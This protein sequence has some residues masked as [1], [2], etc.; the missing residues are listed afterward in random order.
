M[1]QRCCFWALPLSPAPDAG[2]LGAI[3]H[4]A[5]WFVGFFLQTGHSANGLAHLKD[6]IPELV[7]NWEMSEMSKKGSGIP[8]LC[9]ARTLCATGHSLGGAMATLAAYDI[10][11]GLQ[12]IAAS[13]I[14]VVCYTFAAPRTGNH[15]FARDYNATVPDTW[16][17][18]NDQVTSCIDI[19]G[20]FLPVAF[21][22][23][24]LTTDR[25]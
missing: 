10:C 13:N 15:A 16:S 4:L 9:Q 6:N 3:P 22:A 20:S 2:A 7:P 12:A 5:Q 21:Q 11:T 24:L 23:L 25:A 14:G 1:L 19:P 17:V 8:V 18:I